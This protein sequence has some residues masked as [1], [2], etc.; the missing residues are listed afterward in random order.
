MCR[1][2]RVSLAARRRPLLEA[3]LDCVAAVAAVVAVFAVVAAFAVVPAT[4]FGLIFDA[5]VVP[6]WIAGPPP[7][8]SSLCRAS[9]LRPA[10]LRALR[11]AALDLA[12][13]SLDRDRESSPAAVVPPVAT[14]VVE[15]HKGSRLRVVWFS[16]SLRAAS[17]FAVA[18]RAAVL[19][20]SCS[21]GS[22][23]RSGSEVSAAA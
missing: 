4:D 3:A 14:R 6:P 17:W 2:P 19:A 5:S 9:Q 20:V 13:M 22:A 11:E 21:A 10:F 23:A 15:W 1:S 18:V 16:I 8:E 7:A 12:V